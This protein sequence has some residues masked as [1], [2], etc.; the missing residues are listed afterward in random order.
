[1]TTPMMS[2]WHA[3]KAAH[4]DGILFFRMGDFFEFFHDDAVRA[5]QLLGLT[6][7]A[8]SKG[9]DAVPMAGIPV[10]TVDAYIRRL[11]RQGEKVVICD[12]VEDP[13]EAQGIVD[14]QI[15]RVV[16]PGTVTE[17]DSL[18]AKDE[19]FLLALTRSGQDFAAAWADV[20][21]GHFFV[22]DFEAK[23]LWDELV[24]LDPAECLIPESLEKDA[25]FHRDFTA[26]LGAPM[27]VRPDRFFESR[28]GFRVLTKHFGTTSLEGFGLETSDA[29]TGAAGAVLAY[30]LDTQ[31][32]AVG[33][34]RS[35][36]R[37]EPGG[38]MALD[39]ATRSSLELVKTL[40]EGERR[41]TLLDA[42]DKTATA[43][44]ARLLKSWILS[45][46]TDPRA[47][48]R[49]R[50][51]VSEFVADP[52][53]LALLRE[54]LSEVL[55]LERLVGRVGC[56]RATPRDLAALRRSIAA[57]PAIA[58]VLAVSSSMLAG[59]LAERLPDLADLTD[60]LAR[61]IVDEPPHVVKDGGVIR[62]GFNAEL[63]ELRSLGKEGQGF[64]AAFQARE[65][66]ATG[67][68][69]KVGFN[70]VFGYY[71]EITN[72]HRERVPDRFIRKQT[73]KNAER[74]I[75]DE[76]K[77]YE[78]KVLHAEERIVRLESELF[79]DL[80]E[81]IA[82]RLDDLQR[83]SV[84]VAEIDV[85][86]SLAKK[87]ADS[88][89]VAPT[90]DDS[91]A[92][93]IVE[94]R[95]PVLAELPGKDPFVPNDVDLDAERRIMLITGPNMAGKSTYI[96][97]TAL[98]AILA[99][100]GSFLPAKSAHIGVVDRVF[101]RVG[102]NDDLARGSSTFM[103]EMLEVANILNNATQKS[104]VILD[105][106]GRGTSTYDG[107]SLAWAITDHLAT[108]IKAK[109]LFATHYHELVEIAE[110][111][112]CV[113]N[114][115]VAVRE[116]G[117]QIIFLHKIVEGGTDKS[118][119]I[120]VARLAGLP[121]RVIDEARRIL[122]ELESRGDAAAKGADTPAEEQ[123]FLFAPAEDPI[124][125]KLKSID[126]DHLT[127]MEALKLLDELRREAR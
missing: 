49:R 112:P 64:I 40:R 50:D 115:N 24:R 45:P 43:M 73:L 51:A 123:L 44:G 27:T 90:V 105:E 122:D 55:D 67:I 109:T 57:L 52:E 9:D 102:A 62:E 69:L 86:A 125:K 13:A 94:G 118:Y 121:R 85:V 48:A 18:S 35:L 31:R 63:D 53:K 71:I 70:R 56:R 34:V 29:V 80:R 17:E 4:P 113:R 92:F 72:A 23:K 61:A 5:S 104:L 107:L 37:V 83:A 100:I 124:R 21:T 6:L 36:T 96:R 88:R 54:A 99:Q 126:I 25:A 58:R 26:F 32:G 68:P 103:V 110:Y 42:L 119:G 3:V 22:A 30:L 117:D 46:L 127:P 111:A 91:G 79:V 65:A 11:V 93:K 8:R 10:K 89:W 14:R 101:T 81:R 120:H 16:T 39:R 95:H 47:I 77:T 2:Q 78:D 116:W 74:Y 82:G 59:E 98:L 66:A 114:Y 60:L 75:T 106:V 7:T 41:G 19:N 12:Q 76:L 15:T 28:D 97:Q 33:Q 20:S 84:V 87:A 108:K 1:M 38:R